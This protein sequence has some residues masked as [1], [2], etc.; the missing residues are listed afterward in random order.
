MLRRTAVMQ[1]EGFRKKLRD[2]LVQHLSVRGEDISR[3]SK[4]ER[5]AQS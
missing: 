2:G 3:L 5:L 1:T 4:F